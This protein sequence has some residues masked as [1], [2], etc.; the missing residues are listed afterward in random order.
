MIKKVNL[1]IKSC[2]GLDDHTANFITQR[3]DNSLQWATDY[4]TT[5]KKNGSHGGEVKTIGGV[6]ALVPCVHLSG[7]YS[8]FVFNHLY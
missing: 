8:L 6:G 7:G 1:Q 2:I 3:G 4:L 5:T